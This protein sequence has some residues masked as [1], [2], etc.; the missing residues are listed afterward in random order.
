MFNWIFN[1]KNDNS[2]SLR[3]TIYYWPEDASIT[4]AE[5]KKW[6]TQSM[7]AIR[8]NQ[9]KLH[10][11]VAGSHC[12]DTFADHDCRN[13]NSEHMLDVPLLFNLYH[14]QAEAYPLQQNSD[15]KKN[16][17]Y[18]QNIILKL[19]SSIVQFFNKPENS[20]NNLWGTSQISKGGGN[21]YIPCCNW[22]CQ[23]NWPDCCNCG[24]NLMLNQIAKQFWQFG[25]I[26]NA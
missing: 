16:N 26:I 20:K 6:W 18:Y 23:D 19:N 25:N 2:V 7:H 9:F 10:W 17:E 14:D 24:Q 11:I 15:N 8:I 22:N 1:I 13:N 4:N 5:S 12:G 21:E 3:D